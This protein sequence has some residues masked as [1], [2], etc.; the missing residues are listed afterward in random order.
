M[1]SLRDWAENVCRI[2]S[3]ARSELVRAIEGHDETKLPAGVTWLEI[4]EREVGLGGVWFRFAP[5][6]IGRRQFEQVFGRGEG[7]VRVPVDAPAKYMTTVQV[8][9]ALHRCTVIAEYRSDLDD[10]DLQGL[11]LRVDRAA[12]AQ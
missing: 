2:S 3:T 1:T 11:Y 9:G 5:G 6:A 7:L 10:V 8:A 12:K 4:D